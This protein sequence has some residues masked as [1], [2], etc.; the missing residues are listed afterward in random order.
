V[1]ADA[2]EDGFAI[3]VTDTFFHLL[4]GLEG[5]DALGA[6]IDTVAGAW[7]ACLAC[8]APLH[9]EDAE[10]TKFNATVSQEGIHNGVERL[11]HDFLGF[12]LRQACLI[13]DLFH[14]LFFSSRIRSPYEI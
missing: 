9:F 1:G 5:D 14:N 7:I 6:D 11:L 8:L 12:Q 2:Q 4:A 3:E 10:I 13:G